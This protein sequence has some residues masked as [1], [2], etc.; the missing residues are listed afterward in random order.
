[1][2]FHRA[3]NGEGPLPFEHYI[4]WLSREFGHAR[5]TQILRELRRLPVG[6]LGPCRAGVP[7]AGAACTGS[8]ISSA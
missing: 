4:G 5:P 6:P 2:A 8:V 7:T 1:M 3:L